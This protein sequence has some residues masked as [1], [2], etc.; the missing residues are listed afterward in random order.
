MKRIILLAM[1]FQCLAGFAHATTIG[2]DSSGGGSELVATFVSIADNI[3]SKSSFSPADHNVLK[4]ALLSSRIVSVKTLVDVHGNVVPEQGQMLA[5]SS[6]GLIQLKESKKGE[7]SWARALAEKR[8]VAYIVIHELFRASG[9]T[10]KEGRSIDDTY[11]LSVMTYRLN[12]VDNSGQL[13]SEPVELHYWKC[14]CFESENDGSPSGGVNLIAINTLRQAE[15]KAASV[16]QKE[17][18]MKNPIARCLQFVGNPNN[19]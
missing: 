8:S 9:L 3:L 16:C 18:L 5:Y 15:K 19:N 13:L 2:V 11:Q 14:Q 17:L 7:D 4:Q 10:N 6:K 12:E 1:T